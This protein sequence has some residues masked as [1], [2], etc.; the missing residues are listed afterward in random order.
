M[1]GV[2]PT[3]KPK[4]TD[5]MQQADHPKHYNQGKVEFIEALQSALSQ[6]EFRGFLRGNALQYLWRAGLKGDNLTD[7]QKARWYLDKLEKCST[8]KLSSL[9]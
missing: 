6:E 5:P 1:T 4:P 7:L 2:N 9:D 3:Y 8:T